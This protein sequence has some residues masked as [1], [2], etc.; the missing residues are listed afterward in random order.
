M[1]FEPSVGLFH[2]VGAGKTAEMVMGCM[3]LRRLRPGPQARRRHPQPHARAVQREW[4][5]LYPQAQLLAASSQDVTRD[6][7]AEFVARAATGD[8]DAIIITQSAF[9]RLPVSAEAEADHVAAAGQ[10]IRDRVT[11]A[12]ENEDRRTVKRAERQALAAEAKDVSRRW[13]GPATMA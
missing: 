4:L 13:T 12:E 9:S 6:R 3:E 1:V 8:W 7:R 10:A 2:E 11:R 5:Q